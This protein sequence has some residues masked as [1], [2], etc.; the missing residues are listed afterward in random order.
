MW[1]DVPW[2]FRTRI[3]AAL[4]LKLLSPREAVAAAERAL[5]RQRAGE[6]KAHGA[7]PPSLR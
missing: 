5:I 2:L 1:L 4:N 6:I 7:T 3:S